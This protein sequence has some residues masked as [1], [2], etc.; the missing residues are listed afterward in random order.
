[1]SDP[2]AKPE[3][4]PEEKPPDEPTVTEQV[5][6]DLKGSVTVEHIS[7]LRDH[8]DK[9]LAELAT[10]HSKSAEEKERIEARL[11]DISD[12]LDT[13]LKQQ[14][15]KEKVKGSETTIVVPPDHLTPTQQ[16]PPPEDSTKTTTEEGTTHKRRMRF[17]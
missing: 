11:Q 12:R 14:E 17:Y 4:K 8:Y 3:E 6:K 5:D 1:M 7:A 13:M 16:N 9:R 15:E 2:E 10:D